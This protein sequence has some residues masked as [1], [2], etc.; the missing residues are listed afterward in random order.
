M[1]ERKFHKLIEKQNTEEKRAVWQKIQA[2]LEPYRKSEKKP[3]FVRY[4]K[5]VVTFAACFVC[6][7]IV[8]PISLR[9]VALNKKVGSGT[10]DQPRYC[11]SDEYQIV[12]AS[13]T[14]KEYA[15]ENNESFL[16]LDWYQ[17]SISC[18]TKYYVDKNTAEVLCLKENIISGETG[19]DVTISISLKD[20]I[21]DF[22][23]ENSKLLDNVQIINEVKI[24]WRMSNIEASAYFEY[25]DYCYYLYFYFP[26]S[27]QTIFDVV[28][29][30][31]ETAA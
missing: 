14:L 24:N 29:Q 10:E 1:N 20:I 22:I 28:Q 23:D 21:M 9:Y 5:W 18:E 7:A 6:L 13:Q 15:E 31:L 27:E 30:M 11:T 4:K 2:E 19:D 26:M 17:N 25:S 12:T 16:Y 8:I 3:F